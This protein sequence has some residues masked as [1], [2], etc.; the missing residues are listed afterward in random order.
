[1]AFSSQIAIKSMLWSKSEERSL[2]RQAGLDNSLLRKR[3]AKK[4]RKEAEMMYSGR[5]CITVMDVDED[6]V[7]QTNVLTKH[8]IIAHRAA[9]V[10]LKRPVFGEL[11]IEPRNFAILLLEKLGRFADS[12]KTSFETKGY[13]H[14]EDFVELAVAQLRRAAAVA[15][16]E[17]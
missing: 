2:E 12:L 7:A 9:K 5:T 13:L 15:R 10:S 14:C 17:E 1:M 16:M 8:G 4:L 6:D 11:K 3:M